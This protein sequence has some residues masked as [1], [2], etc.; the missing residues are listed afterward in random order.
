MA[1]KDDDFI[2]VKWDGLQEFAD[3]LEGMEHEVERIAIE[4]MTKYGLLVEEVTKALAPKETG[5]LEQS[6]NFGKAQ[7]EGQEIVVAGGSNLPYALKRHEA[8]YKMGIRDK[9]DN[10]A[11]FED[12]YIGGKGRRTLRKP[13]WNGYKPGRKFLQNAIN[14]TEKEYDKMN[15]RILERLLG[16]DKE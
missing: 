11:V 14:A 9:Y 10:G 3:L 8:P 2:S 5:D 1:K 13:T 4:E 16:G 7:R 15:E 12:Y 6:I